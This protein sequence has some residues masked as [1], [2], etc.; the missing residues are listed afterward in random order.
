VK[1]EG[2]RSSSDALAVYILHT[3]V[4]R[5]AMPDW[6][7]SSRTTPDLVAH[8]TT[9][10]TPYPIEGTRCG[11]RESASAPQMVL[12]PFLSLDIDIS[13]FLFSISKSECN[14]Y[15]NLIIGVYLYII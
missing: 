6:D 10:T 1:V 13:I 5:R 9:L 4:G 2:R 11:S 14:T 8:V 7:G 15:K 3:A 12:L